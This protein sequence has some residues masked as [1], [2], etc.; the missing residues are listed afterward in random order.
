[1]ESRGAGRNGQS[2]KQDQG[3]SMPSDFTLRRT[4]L[5]DLDALVEMRMG[6]LRE[7]GN[8]SSDISQSELAA[9]TEAHRHYFGDSVATERYVGFVAEIDGR[10]VGTGGLVL[11]ERPPYKGNLAGLEA[12]LMN[13]YTVPQWRG[14]GIATAIVRQIV[15]NAERFGAKRVWLHTEP[16]AQRLYEKAGF[17]SKNSEMEMLL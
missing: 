14:K 3:F 4:E 10:I 2:E 8:V 12:Y 17:V 5:R 13:V 11:L 15:N 1:M 6:L 16:G 9:V 7:V